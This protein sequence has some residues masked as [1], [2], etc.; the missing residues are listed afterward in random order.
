MY[1]VVHNHVFSV[2]K[3]FFQPRHPD[4][5]KRDIVAA[6]NQFH[7]LF[8]GSEHYGRC[9]Y[10]INSRSLLV[11]LWTY[12]V[13]ND[14]RQSLSITLNGTVPINYRG[15]VA[16]TFLYSKRFF[17]TLN[18]GQVYNIPVCLYISE[19]HPY[20]PPICYVRPTAGMVIR[21]GPNVDTSGRV[22]LPYLQQWKHVQ[23]LEYLKNSLQRESFKRVAQVRLVRTDLV[24]GDDLQRN[25]PGFLPLVQLVVEFGH[26]AQSVS[27]FGTVFWCVWNQMLP[28]FKTV[29]IYRLRFRTPTTAGAVPILP[30]NWFGTGS[31]PAVSWRCHSS[32]G[33]TTRLVLLHALPTGGRSNRIQS[34]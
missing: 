27:G 24:D 8:P 25:L 26:G 16:C 2:N 13:Y 14:G 22:Y 23:S 3:S 1:L 5:V 29:T 31:V 11:Y 10:V 19:T 17:D 4:M 18:K 30:I 7:D 20:N 32:G 21:Q 12:L 6:L 28:K 33:S 15:I 9:S 34:E